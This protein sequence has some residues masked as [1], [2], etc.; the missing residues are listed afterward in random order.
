MT[1]F[2]EL[3][4]VMKSVR[5]EARH[6]GLDSGGV[7]GQQVLLLGDAFYG[8]R[9]TG[10]EFTALWSAAAQT[11]KIFDLTGKCLGVSLLEHSA[12]ELL[13]EQES[14]RFTNTV[15]QTRKAA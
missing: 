1:E 3:D 4:P 8:Y 9:F 5:R 12:D 2:E 10:K 14:L 6:Y 7:V 15:Y 13:D 11:L